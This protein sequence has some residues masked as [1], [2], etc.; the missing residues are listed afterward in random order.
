MKSAVVFFILLSFITFPA[1][2]E[3]SAGDVE[4]NLWGVSYHHKRPLRKENFHELN[5]GVGLR[6]YVPSPIEG[7]ETFVT[8]D[9]I[10]KNTTGGK[11]T[12]VGIGGLYPIGEYAGVQFLVGGVV[13]A[14]R[15]EDKWSG[16]TGIYPGGYPVL[17]VRYDRCTLT[18]GHIIGGSHGDKGIVSATFMYTGFRF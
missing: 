16:D 4:M 13:G 2:A 5:P 15:Y 7:F 18:L 14:V 10:R 9:H 12:Q 3:R 17:S 1:F 8:V 6:F 11:A